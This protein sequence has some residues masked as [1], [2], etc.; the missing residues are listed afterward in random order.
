MSQGWGDV[1]E[2]RSPTAGQV[3]FCPKCGAMLPA[4]T[5][6]CTACGAR[7]QP[8]IMDERTGFTWSDFFSYSLVAILFAVGALLIPLLICGVLYGV[9]LLLAP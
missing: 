6:R 8:R 4:G 5:Q 3:D 7:V 1:P 2:S 9:F